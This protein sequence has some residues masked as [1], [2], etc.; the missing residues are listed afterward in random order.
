MTLAE[1]FL[2]LNELDDAVILIEENQPKGIITSKDAIHLLHS[3]CD[4]SDP[5]YR[6]MTA[7]LDTVGV[8]LTIVARWITLERNVLSASL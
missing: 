3:D 1:V 6:H 7:P 2:Q 4:C 5:A 8:D